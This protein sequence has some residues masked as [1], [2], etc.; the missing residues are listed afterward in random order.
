VLA[1]V[2]R[3]GGLGIVVIRGLSKKCMITGLDLA[4]FVEMPDGRFLYGLY[5]V[6]PHAVATTRRSPSTMRRLWRTRGQHP[7]IPPVLRVGGPWSA[8]PG[9]GDAYPLSGR[10]LPIGL[11]LPKNRRN[12][13]GSYRRQF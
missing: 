11:E 3:P 7:S 13:P 9:G 12:L 1:L 6:F 4:P 5:G 2:V 10:V 8:R